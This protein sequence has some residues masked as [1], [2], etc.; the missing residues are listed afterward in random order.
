M[1]TW[2]STLVAL[3]SLTLG[4]D[5]KPAVAILSVDELPAPAAFVESMR[6]QLTGMA[7][8]ATGPVISGQSRA[9]KAAQARQHLLRVGASNAVWVSK[10]ARLVGAGGKGMLWGSGRFSGWVEGWRASWSVTLAQ[11]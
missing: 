11:K 9:D 10:A 5:G 2:L 1:A 8:V 3:T 4:A 7:S 6:I